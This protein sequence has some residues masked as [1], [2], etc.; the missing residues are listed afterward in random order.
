MRDEQSHI[1]VIDIVRPVEMKRARLAWVAIAIALVVGLSLS[2]VGHANAAYEQARESSGPAQFG[3]PEQFPQRFQYAV[4]MAVNQTGV[5]GVAPGSLYTTS[6]SGTV[7]RLSPGK[8]GE[9]PQVEEEW[10][11]GIIQPG[12]EH[13]FDRCGPAYQGAANPA[14]HIYE[15]CSNR[16]AQG[17]GSPAELPG[18]FG[19][20]PT[21][22]VE[23]TPSGPGVHGERGNHRRRLRR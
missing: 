20:S 17:Q 23:A 4:S 7:V 2:L 6:R 18:Q 3:K 13:A 16:G 21:I 5:G 22:A 14:E 11:W 10:G 19:L 15:E 8:E 1:D 9:E 12:D